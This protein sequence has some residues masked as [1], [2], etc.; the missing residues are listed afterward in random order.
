MAPLFTFYN[1]NNLKVGLSIKV[2]NL[3][4]IFCLHNVTIINIQNNN[5]CQVKFKITALELILSKI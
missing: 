1:H 5:K 4:A 2:I 3:S